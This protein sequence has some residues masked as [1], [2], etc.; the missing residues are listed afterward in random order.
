MRN[1]IICCSFVHTSR[2][3]HNTV[4]FQ[5]YPA[6]LA[7][8]FPQYV[9]LNPYSILMRHLLCYFD[10]KYKK[11]IIVI[12]NILI[13]HY[14]LLSLHFYPTRAESAILIFT[15]QI[16]LAINYIIAT[17]HTSMMISNLFFHWTTSASRLSSANSYHT[18]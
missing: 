7:F 3:K 2:N 12:L 5:E 8:V 14:R 10:L 6:C 11:Y 13:C 1:I 16:F 9:S 4:L 15:L 17:L 18:F